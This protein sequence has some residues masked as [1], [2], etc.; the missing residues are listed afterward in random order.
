MTT[1]A[2]VARRHLPGGTP[3]DDARQG[4][5]LWL[6]GLGAVLFVYAATA[7]AYAV[8]VPLGRSADE[9][10]HLNY[11]RII[12]DHG[13][14]PGAT[15][16][17]RQQPPLYYLMAAGLLKLGVPEQGLRFASIL[18]GLLAIVAIAAVA[19]VVVPGHPWLAVA[20]AGTVALLPGFQDLGGSISNDPLAIAVGAALLLLT[21]LVLAADSPSR[22]LLLS[23][24]AVAG[25]ALLAKETDWAL[26]VV[27]AI[28]IAVRWRT[29]LQ[30]QHLLPL[31]GLPV[32]IAGWWF[33]RNLAEFHRPLPPLS[34][35]EQHQYLRHVGQ[36]RGFASETL[37][38]L[39]G[40]ERFQGGLVSLPGA[41]DALVVV[42]SGALL[43]SLLVALVL[44]AGSWRRWP[45]VVIVQA[46]FLGGAIAAALLVSLGNSIVLDLQPQARYLLVAAAGPALAVALVW[47]HIGQTHPRAVAAAVALAVL[48]ALTLSAIGIHTAATAAG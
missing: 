42:L 40:P 4:S 32:L 3:G 41:G 39:F 35:A 16:L 9:F 12:A 10:S 25:V 45:G 44:A 37:R 17:E 21:V 27:L 43:L 48:A 6:A 30:P 19:R 18:F 26:L 28:A 34:L 24:G 29:Q 8:S 11:A 33:V 7:T 13:A 5:R 14:L 38:D 2:A 15:V 20:A 23:V 31:L 46:L 47:A 36:L 1:E 22:G